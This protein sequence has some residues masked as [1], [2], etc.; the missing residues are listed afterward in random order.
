MSDLVITLVQT[1][2][3]W[4]DKKQNLLL[5]EKWL[6]EVKQPTDFVVLP[7]M[8]STAFSMQTALADTTDGETI[9]WMKQQSA[10]LGKPICGSLML[11]ENGSFYNRFIWMQPDG[12]FQFYNKRHLFRMGNEHDHFTAGNERIIIKSNGWKLFPVVC[13]DLRFPVWLRR[14]KNFDYD[15]MI[16]VANW[17]ERR[18][19]HWRTL[20]QARA[21][22]NQCYVIAVNRV[23]VDGNGVNHSGYSG[24]VSPK[25]E[26]ILEMA[27]ST[28]IQN[29]TMNKHDL[30]DWRTTFPA[31]ND[32]DD[33][34]LV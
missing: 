30:I 16:I 24:V 11:S 28:G 12:E 18:E 5:L 15:A 19:H 27:D 34:M 7:E 10:K 6:S 9:A 29:V 3:H 17:P 33:F 25:G 26:W 22:E 13:Y 32:A 8:F 14:T 23:G 1:T 31:E 21:I 4:E 20:L 2:L